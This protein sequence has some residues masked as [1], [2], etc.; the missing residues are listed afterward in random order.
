M[1]GTG[2]ELSIAGRGGTAGGSEEDGVDVAGV[3]GCVAAGVP[4]SQ[5][6]GGEAIVGWSV[7]M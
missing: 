5:G 2:C 4:R 6:F 3:D 1:T 7:S